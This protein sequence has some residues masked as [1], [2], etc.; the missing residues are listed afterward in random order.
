M[1]KRNDYDR[2]Y[3]QNRHSLEIIPGLVWIIETE[4]QKGDTHFEEGRKTL[5][6]PAPDPNRRNIPPD[7]QTEWNTSVSS[8]CTDTGNTAAEAIREMIAE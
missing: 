6:Q 8:T 4:R 5:E 1:L 7:R 2:K 3:E